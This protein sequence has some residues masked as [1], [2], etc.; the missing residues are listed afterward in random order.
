MHIDEIIKERTGL[1]KIRE[2]S[3]RTGL[4]LSTLSRVI[5]HK[6]VADLKTLHRISTHLDIPMGDLIRSYGY[7]CGCALHPHA[8]HDS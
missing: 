3:A 4:P 6:A 7:E 2:I 1:I 5:R 8:A